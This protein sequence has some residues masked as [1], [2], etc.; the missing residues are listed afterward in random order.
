[1]KKPKVVVIDDESMVRSVVEE[2]FDKKVGPATGIEFDVQGFGRCPEDITKISDANIF[3]IDYFM[4]GK[5]GDEIAKELIDLGAQG[6]RVLI[7]ADLAAAIGHMGN[8]KKSLFKKTSTDRAEVAQATYE[9][10]ESFPHLMRKPFETDALTNLAFKL[11]EERK[12]KA[13]LNVGVIGLGKLGLGTVQEIV[14]EGWVTQVGAFTNFVGGSQDEY[15]KLLD[16]LDLSGEERDKIVTHSD[17]EGLIETNPDVIV[18]ATGEHDT[19]YFEYKDRTKLTE[20][21]FRKGLPKI[22]AILESV[23]RLNCQ[24][25]L[26]IESNPNGHYIHHAIRKGINP[27]QLTSF[28]PDTMRHVRVIYETLKKKHPDLKEEEIE[29]M[30][31]GEHMKGGTPLYNEAKVRGIPLTDFDPRFAKRGFQNKK[32]REARKQGLE[33]MQSSTRYSHDYRGVPR[34]VKEGL[35]ELAH[36]QPTSRNPI[37]AGRISVPATFVYSFHDGVCYPRVRPTHQKITEF[38]Q[39]RFATKEIPNDIEKI[40]RQEREWTKN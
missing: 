5:K 2:Q 17:L 20:R 24:S 33:V 32:T 1:M 15:Q 16:S 35:Q 37:Y 4:E 19:P 28:S 22:D 11:R 36:F 12:I 10:H 7:T 18:I 8:I 9:I 38:T 3:F 26:A 13:P 40:K 31:I 34:R 21:L 27:F 6:E 39:D 23:Q 25:L 30:V 29:L 14:K